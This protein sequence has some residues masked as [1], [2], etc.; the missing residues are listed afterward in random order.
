MN[1]GEF[2]QRGRDQ[3]LDGA[4][5]FAPENLLED[6]IVSRCISVKT[7][8]NSVS[9]EPVGFGSNPNFEL[10]RYACEGSGGIAAWMKLGTCRL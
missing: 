5:G 8:W 4:L 2:E 9:V 7:R 1:R 3:R 6:S 10:Y